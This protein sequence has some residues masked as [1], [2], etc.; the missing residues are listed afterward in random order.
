MTHDPLDA[1]LSQPLPEIADNGFSA[2]VIARI[3]AEERRQ[4]ATIALIAILCAT[5]L[6]LAVP[7]RDVTGAIAVAVLQL[8]A[9]P[10]V[11]YG[12]AAL[13]LTLLIDRAVTNRSPSF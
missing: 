9:S 7:M 3:V 4:L 6:C 2:R 13:V 5:L 12:L 10:M 1:L 11:L 8:G